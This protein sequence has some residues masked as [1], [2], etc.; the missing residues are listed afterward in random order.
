MSTTPNAL[1]SAKRA[2]V[3][4]DNFTNNV[5]K[6][7]GTGVN[8]F[9]PSYKQVRD[10]RRTAASTAPPTA[11]PNE[12]MGVRENQANELNTALASREEARKALN[13]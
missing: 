3:K 13:Q 5:V 7:S 12:F 1:A 9:K 8:A 2:L 4:A 11:A 10:N 6:Q